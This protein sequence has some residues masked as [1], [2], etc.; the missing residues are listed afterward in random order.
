MKIFTPIKLVPD[1]VEELEIAGDG[2]SLD[3]TWMRLVNNE[4]DQHA[5]EQAILLKELHGAEVSV[6]TTEAEDAAE[7]LYTAAAMGADRLIM[8]TGLDTQVDNQQLA[9]LY[10]D[11]FANE[12]PDLILA[13]VQ[14]HNDLDGQLGALIAGHLDLPYIGY[15][16]NV[17]IENDK[18]TVHKEFP[19][20]LIAIMETRLP[21]V[22]GIQAAAQ[23]PRYVAFSRIQQARKT[24]LIEK[25]PV[26]ETP[27]Q[28]PDIVKMYLPQSTEKAIM[29]EGG[30]NDVASKLIDILEDV[31]VR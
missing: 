5:I 6:F 16:S 3:T 14:A 9:I 17:I 27:M 28:K 25:I 23:P 19:G 1:L 21:A 2:K 11:I 10:K 7:V 15:V 31:G 30:P 18:A 29:I 26:L 4:F 8:L 20:G 22:F 12:K 24:L 13:G